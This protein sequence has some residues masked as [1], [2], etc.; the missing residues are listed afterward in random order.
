MHPSFNKIIQTF[1]IVLITSF[2]LAANTNSVRAQTITDLDQCASFARPAVE[3]LINN[4]IV[5]GSNGKFNP[6][7]SLTRAQLVKMIVVSL[8]IDISDPPPRP[9]F[10]DVV[11]T[12]WSYPYVEAA[13]ENGIIAIGSEMLFNPDEEASREQ[14]AAM[15]VRALGITNEML[16]MNQQIDSVPRLTDNSIVSS[17]AANSVEFALDNGIMVGVGGNKFAPRDCAE[18]QQA[19][20]VIYRYLMNKDHLLNVKSSFKVG[21][22]FITLGSTLNDV[23][24]ILGTE[25]YHGYYDQ[26]Y[27]YIERYN[28][29]FKIILETGMDGIGAGDT[30]VVGWYNRDINDKLIMGPTDPTAAPFKIGSSINDVAQASGTPKSIFTH[31]RYYTAPDYYW[32]SYPDNSVVYFD[33]SRNV[34]GYINNG[35]LKVSMGEKDLNAAPVNHKSNVQDLIK[36][37]GTP[38]II[39]GNNYLDYDYKTNI[40]DTDMLDNNYTYYQYKNSYFAFDQKQKLIYFVNNNNLNI[41][42]GKKDPDFPG[43]TV[44][45]TEDD[46]IKAMGTPEKIIYYNL[47]IR[48]WIYGDS[49]VFVSDDGF[50]IGWI[51]K[52][53]LTIRQNDGDLNAPVIGL[54]STKQ[55]VIKL[56]GTPLELFGSNWTYA[57][58]RITFDSNERVSYITK[59]YTGILSKNVKDDLSP[60]FTFGSTMNEVI[61]AMGNPDVVRWENIK[62]NYTCWKYDSA[63]L[64]F[65]SAGKVVQWGD[66]Q[67][68]L[69]MR[70]TPL[71]NTDASPITL[72]STADDV[73]RTMGLPNSMTPPYL[74]YIEWYYAGGTIILNNGKVTGWQNSSKQMKVFIGDAVEGATFKYGSTKDDVTKAMGTPDSIYVLS[75]KEVWYYADSWVG[76][77][78]VTGEVSGWKSETNLRI[79][80]DTSF[81]TATAIKIGSTRD[82]VFKVMGLPSFHESQGFGRTYCLYGQSEVTFDPQGLVVSWWNQDNNLILE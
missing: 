81:S 53:N 55:D 43:I 42:F 76:F 2:L 9:S 46:I 10:K 3:Y 65:D 34:I 78:L 61:T 35:S 77:D 70:Q 17:W 25:G 48:N 39:S 28:S 1:L 4:G 74:I 47:N 40:A 29:W 26:Q 18:R 67:K 12:H 11:A 60:G 21:K 71:Y 62:T 64:Y 37:L 80:A 14:M 13:L 75:I 24:E 22:P 7:D 44:S 27:Y 38:D 66:S 15:F 57:G 72:G 59:P 45:S 54:G 33:E 73:L 49:S 58:T 20:L 82:D 5:V 6:R 32:M 50:I 52:G 23:Y 79:T 69:K 8:G 41:D 68:I 16:L 19:A 36:T 56:M 63:E 30:K 51:N 31:R